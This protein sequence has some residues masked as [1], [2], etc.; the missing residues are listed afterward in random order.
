MT[1]TDTAAV[2]DVDLAHT[3]STCLASWTSGHFELT[4]S[5]LADDVTFV[6]PLATTHGADAYVE[7]VR[8][9]ARMVRGLT[10]QQLLVEG[11]NVCIRYELDV[12]QV[13]PIPTVGW[14]HFRNG[15]IDSVQAYFDPRP[16]TELRSPTDGKPSTPP[17]PAPPRIDAVD[18]P[19]FASSLQVCA[20]M[21]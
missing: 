17:S 3:A 7:G 18:I 14:Y 13:G 19:Q 21:Y 12:E 5:L 11:D 16:V 20:E 10:L 15:R 2:S 6:G 8:G 1:A 9:M 4:R